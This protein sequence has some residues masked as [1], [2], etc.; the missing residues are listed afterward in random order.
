MGGGHVT[1]GR[2]LTGVRVVEGEQ[3]VISGSKGLGVLGHVH[4]AFV[5]RRLG[6]AHVDLEGRAAQR[7]VVPLHVQLVGSGH[8]HTWGSCL[9]R[10]L[11]VYNVW[12]GV[13]VCATSESVS[14]STRLSQCL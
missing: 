8:L 10:C 12:V 3:H 4:D 9:S 5:G 6:R 1:N 13:C 7:V 14:E 11:C 2:G